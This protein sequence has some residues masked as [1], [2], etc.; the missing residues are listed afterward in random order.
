MR[1]ILRSSLVAALVFAG[2]RPHM[3][4]YLLALVM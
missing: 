2:L 3:A 4:E 1:T